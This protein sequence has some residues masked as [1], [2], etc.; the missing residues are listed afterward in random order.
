[1]A[2]IR[3]PRGS[4]LLAALLACALARA[5]GAGV[6][7][8]RDAPIVWEMD[9]R[10]DAPRPAERDPNLLRD[11]IEESFIFPIGRFFNPSRLVRKVGVLFGGGHLLPPSDPNPPDGVPHSAWCPTRVGVLQGAAA[12]DARV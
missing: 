9:D 6:P 2:A 3:S 5:A 8:L 12:R 7:P 11:G 10:K 4:A 1:M